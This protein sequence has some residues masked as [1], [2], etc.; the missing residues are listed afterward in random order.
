MDLLDSKGVKTSKNIIDKNI[1]NFY[2]KKSEFIDNPVFYDDSELLNI[3]KLNYLNDGIVCK[4]LIKNEVKDSLYFTNSKYLDNSLKFN[5]KIITPNIFL[6]EVNNKI[7][8]LKNIVDV[9]EK[10]DKEIKDKDS[11]IIEILKFLRNNNYIKY[12]DNLLNLNNLRLLVNRIFFEYYQDLIFYLNKLNQVK[13]DFFVTENNILLLLEN[14]Y[15]I[16]HELENI[17]SQK[18]YLLTNNNNDKYIIKESNGN[19]NYEKLINIIQSSIE[20]I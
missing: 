18:I 6:T 13:Y 19:I 2:I 16:N 20:N 4:T 12:L 7:D 17:I 11:N 10:N 15:K 9:I 1:Y 14:Y 3:L 8:K 5:I